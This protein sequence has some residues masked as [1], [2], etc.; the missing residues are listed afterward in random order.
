MKE[1][2]GHRSYIAW[3][4]SLWINNDENLY[5]EALRLVQKYGRNRA[6]DIMAFYLLDGCN[7]CCE[8][9]TK[10]PITETMVC[11]MRG[12]TPDGGKY[13]RLTIFLAMEGMNE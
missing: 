6:A 2:N 8:S 3:N 7:T 4:V 5:R 10:C 12:R 11:R 9:H 13:N 1:Y